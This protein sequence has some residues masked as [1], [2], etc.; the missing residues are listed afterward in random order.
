MGDAPGEGRMMARRRVPVPDRDA[1]EVAAERL[2]AQAAVVERWSV[3]RARWL[4]CLA[5]GYEAGAIDPTGELRRPGAAPSAAWTR[6]RR[7]V[8]GWLERQGLPADPPEAR[9]CPTLTSLATPAFSTSGSDPDVSRDA[10]NHG[11]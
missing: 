7:Q 2:R 11:R 8:V 4:R 5:D 3:D 9:D 10:D 6:T 1:A